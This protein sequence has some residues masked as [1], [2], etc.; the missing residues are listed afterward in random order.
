MAVGRF[1]GSASEGLQ[2]TTHRDLTEAQVDILVEL[3]ADADCTLDDLPYTDAFE[4]LC[5]QFWS[6]A[7]VSLDRHYV[8]K[9]L[10]NARKASKLMRKER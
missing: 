10:C 4:Q 7:G 3:Y 5:S 1:R 2:M 6:R 9:A 8:W